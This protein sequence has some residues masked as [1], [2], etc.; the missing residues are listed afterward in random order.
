M[1]RGVTMKNYVVLLFVCGAV[2]LVSLALSGC[3]GN[4][5][6]RSVDNLDIAIVEMAQR[7]ELDDLILMDFDAAVREDVSYRFGN[8]VE[9]LNQISSSLSQGYAKLADDIEGGI[10]ACIGKNELSQYQ[11]SEWT[12]RNIGFPNWIKSIRGHLLLEEA[13]SLK[14]QVM[15]LKLAKRKDAAPLVKQREE[16]LRSLIDQIAS[17]TGDEEWRE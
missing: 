14:Y 8:P 9:Q 6:N 15:L 4:T 10:Y 13:R 16:A 5:A 7:N 3:A 17:L 1:G 12:Y 11:G 2:G